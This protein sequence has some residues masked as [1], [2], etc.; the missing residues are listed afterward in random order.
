M[1]A[2]DTPERRAG[3]I[4]TSSFSADQAFYVGR[5]TSN[6]WLGRPN[7]ALYGLM[8]NPVG[9]AIRMYM[10]N[11]ANLSSLL[12]IYLACSAPACMGKATSRAEHIM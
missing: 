4:S 8:G 7:A 3:S 1:R 11:H 5:S 10:Q 6:T 2:A 12:I 9:A